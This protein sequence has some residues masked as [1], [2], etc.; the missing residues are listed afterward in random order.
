MPDEKRLKRYL[1]VGAVVGAVMAL[2][3][4][5]LMDVFF[6]DSLS[7][8]W[9]DAIVT[10]L[11]NLLKINVTLNSPIV[12]IVFG[13]ILAVLSGFGAFMGM[14]FTFFIIRFFSFLKG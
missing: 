9:R 13:I 10:D 14:I 12:V 3:I 11:H 6:A 1:I 7:G 4:S 2:T 8:T 5:L